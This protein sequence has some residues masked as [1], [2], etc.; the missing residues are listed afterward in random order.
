MSTILNTIENP[1]EGWTTVE[2]AAGLIG[3]SKHTLYSWVKTGKITCFSVGKKI[4]VVNIEEVR[5]YAQNRRPLK[6]GSID[7]TPESE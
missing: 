2:D 4:M 6:S 3:R 7:K 1:F 5:N